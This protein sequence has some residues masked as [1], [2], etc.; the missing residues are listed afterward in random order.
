MKGGGQ[1]AIRGFQV[2]TLIALL[3]ALGEERLW[4][5]VTLEPNVDSE[6]VDIL[7]QYP[8]RTEAV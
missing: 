3:K 2:E 7:W 4:T 1:V 8:S 5:S 6:K